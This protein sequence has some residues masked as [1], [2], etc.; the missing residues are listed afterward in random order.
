M[1]YTI[2]RADKIKMGDVLAGTASRGPMSVKEVTKTVN[3]LFRTTEIKVRGPLG[4]IEKYYADT[5]VRMAYVEG[6]N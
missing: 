4:M 3:P 5:P 6:E 2:I 1:T